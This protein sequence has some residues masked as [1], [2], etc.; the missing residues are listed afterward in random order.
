MP[1][2]DGPDWT[3]NRWPSRATEWLSENHASG[4][5]KRRTVHG[6]EPERLISPNRADHEVPATDDRPMPATVETSVSTICLTQGTKH[7]LPYLPCF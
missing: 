3:R 1:L 5:P 4:E 6:V 2:N 7:L